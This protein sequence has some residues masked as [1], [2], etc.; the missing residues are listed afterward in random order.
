MKIRNVLLRLGYVSSSGITKL[1]WVKDNL[2]P[3]AIYIDLED[4]LVGKT[5]TVPLITDIV[6]A[7]P[8]M[9]ST[10]K[11]WKVCSDW[12][13][14]SKQPNDISSIEGLIVFPDYASLESFVLSTASMPKQLSHDLSW[15]IPN[16]VHKNQFITQ[17]AIRDK[18]FL[19]E[20]GGGLTK[21]AT[22]I[23]WDKGF[24][25]LR[26]RFQPPTPTPTPKKATRRRK[27]RPSS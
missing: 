26:H 19:S 5:V 18:T 16:C 4:K 27:K 3:C 15:T 23:N 10:E 6:N 14:D 24:E 22:K 20:V 13:Y 21:I 8:G 11:T 25:W 7:I 12:E 2:Q 1:L 17:D 9:K